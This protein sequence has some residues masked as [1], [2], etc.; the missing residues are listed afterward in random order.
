MGF[1]AL[2]HMGKDSER[3]MRAGCKSFRGVGILTV[4]L[5]SLQLQAR[6][7]EEVAKGEVLGLLVQRGVKLVFKQSFCR[8]QREVSGVCLVSEPS[9][10][11]IRNQHCS[12]ASGSLFQ[13]C[14]LFLEG[15]VAGTMDIGR[16]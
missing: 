15:P 2:C 8:P 9:Y 4:N 11:E 13:D 7:R 12:M 14:N 6:I 10:M 16:S 3:A 1:K 5:R